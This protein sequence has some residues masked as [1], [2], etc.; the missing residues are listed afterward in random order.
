MRSPIGAR[1]K[2]FD[3]EDGTA[4][5]SADTTD[6]GSQC[7]FCGSKDIRGGS[8]STDSCVRCGAVYHMGWVKE[9]KIESKK[10]YQQCNNC[11]STNIDKQSGAMGVH[12]CKSCGSFSSISWREIR[13]PKDSFTQRI[14]NLMSG[15]SRFYGG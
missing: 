7:P 12:T 3:R 1:I 11:G 8:W 15:K 13:P 9:L 10:T 5:L 2:R 14:V 4:Y 6:A